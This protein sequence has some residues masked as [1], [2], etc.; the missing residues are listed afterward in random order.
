[1]PKEIVI[2]LDNKPGS[3][4]KVAETLG[5]AGVNFEGVGYATGVRGLLRIV[6]NNDEKALNALTGAKVKVK[7]VNEVVDVTLP[8]TPGTLGSMARKLA[9]ARINIDAFYVVGSEPGGLRCIV[10]VD[11]PDK[12]RALLKG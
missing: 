12:A 11:K 1:M 8:D 7:K 4:A 6:T 2:P 3:L 9:K 5:A 10:A